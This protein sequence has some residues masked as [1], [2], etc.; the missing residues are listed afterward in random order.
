MRDQ[1][2]RRFFVIFSVKKPFLKK[3]VAATNNNRTV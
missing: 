3:D 1:A 2:R